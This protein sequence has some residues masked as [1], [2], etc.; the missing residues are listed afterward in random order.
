MKLLFVHQHFGAFGGAEANILLT[1]RELQRRGHTVG[2]LYRQRTGRSEDSWS[3]AFPQSFHLP[4]DGNLELV[5]AV[6]ER[7][8]P[9][10]IY[11]HNLGDLKVLEALLA[12]GI[13]VVRMVHDHEMYCLRGY[14]YNY[15]TRRICTRGASL[16]CV[17]PCGA[18]VTRNP[19]GKFPLKWASYFQKVKEIRLNRR[20]DQ[21]VVYSD[22]SKQELLRNGFD[23]RKIHIHVPIPCWGQ[24]GPASSFNPKRNLILFVGQII[25]GK[26]V[27][28]L[29]EALA[30]VTLPFECHILG[31]GNH[32]AKCERLSDRLGLKSKVQ[33]NG[34][35][36]REELEHY[37]LEAT[38]LAVSSV[39]P[40]PFGMVGPEAMRYGLPVVAFDAGGIREWLTDGENGYVVPW[41]DTSR[42]AARLEQLLRD[43]DLARQM[44]RR[45][46]ERVNRDYD[47]SRQIDTLEALFTRVLSEPK[48]GSAERSTSQ[49]PALNL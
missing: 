3:L 48:T 5:E 1:A 46:L 30:K 36:R 43:K 15:F 16:Y 40:E 23:P 21:F 7:F 18:C 38:V 20:C 44:G 2:L 47:A 22:Y 39:W 49:K 9:E 37:Y 32:R 19:K 6:L 41:M 29:L 11:F 17:F 13:P 33:F 26:G 12:T 34:Y 45:G 42:F 31:D 10:L 35:V 25:R 8:A 27:D 24:N 4:T 28:L 14:K